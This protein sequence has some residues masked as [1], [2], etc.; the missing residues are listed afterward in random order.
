MNVKMMD[1]GDEITIKLPACPAG[2]HG[3]QTGVGCPWDAIECNGQ[4]V[5]FRVILN[6]Q[7]NE[8][9]EKPV[10]ILEPVLVKGQL[11]EDWSGTPKERRYEFAIAQA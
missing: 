2:F 10:Y 3:G 8:A 1:E 9:A 5:T 6:P 4:F 7:W 11:S